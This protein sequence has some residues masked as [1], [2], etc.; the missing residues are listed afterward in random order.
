MLSPFFWRPVNRSWLFENAE[1]S[2]VKHVYLHIGPKTCLTNQFNITCSRT[3]SYSTRLYLLVAGNMGRTKLQRSWEE[4]APYKIVS[5]CFW[6]RVKMYQACVRERS[7]CLEFV[8]V[9]VLVL[10]FVNEQEDARRRLRGMCGC[11]KELRVCW[12]AM[13]RKNCMCCGSILSLV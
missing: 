12:M 4:I 13:E 2:L 5:L 7:V 11:K 6:L 9:V 3:I 10:M 8:I 1:V